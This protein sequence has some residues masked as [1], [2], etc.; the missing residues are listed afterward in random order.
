MKLETAKSLL[1]GQSKSELTNG[2]AIHEAKIEIFTS[3]E[4]RRD[5]P[6]ML[7]VNDIRKIIN[8]QDPL[9]KEELFKAINENPLVKV[10]EQKSEDNKY[11]IETEFAKGDFARVENIDYQKGWCH[12]NCIDIAHRLEKQNA[13]CEVLTGLMSPLK[14]AGIVHSVVLYKDSIV[15]VADKLSMDKSLYEDMFNFKELARVSSDKIV[16]DWPKVK[17]SGISKKLYLLA[18]EDVMQELK[19]TGIED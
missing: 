14:T 4:A 12:E 7:L 13:K 16:K 2:R 6:N 17:K 15:D 8:E 19:A 1:K 3:H 18:R 9:K 11:H 10:F 5:N